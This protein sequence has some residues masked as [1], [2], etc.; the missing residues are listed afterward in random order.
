MTFGFMSSLILFVASAIKLG[1]IVLFAWLLWRLKPG[2]LAKPAAP[3]D[4]IAR[5]T[6]VQ[7]L[8]TLRLISEE[9]FQAKRREILQRI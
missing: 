3:V 8:R 5:L 7:K 9:E 6:E 1:V 4:P 2:D